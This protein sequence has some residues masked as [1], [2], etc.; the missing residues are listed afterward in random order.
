[1]KQKAFSPMTENRKQKR[2]NKK[3]DAKAKEK[4]K[5]EH[6]QQISESKKRVAE[7]Y[8]QHLEHA[9][10]KR[11]ELIK[12]VTDEQT[13]VTKKNGKT[14]Y[15]I[16]V[17]QNLQA[18]EKFKK[19]SDLTLPNGDLNKR[20]YL[21]QFY[22]GKEMIERGEIAPGIKIMTKL[23]KV[24]PDDT[25]VLQ[26][27]GSAS[28]KINNYHASLKFFEEAE[29]IDPD[30]LLVQVAIASLY[31]RIDKL[32]LAQ[33]KIQ[34]VLKNKNLDTQSESE[35]S[36][37]QAHIYSLLG[38]KDKSKEFIT[39]ACDLNPDNVEFLYTMA[40]QN[41]CIKD[42]KSPYFKK[43]KKFEKEKTFEKEHTKSALMHYALFD[44]Y[45][46][47]KDYE[48]AFDYAL[49]GAKHKEKEAPYY[50]PPLIE[51]GMQQ[52]RNFF[53]DDLLSSQ[54]I[55]GYNSELPVFVTGMPRSGTTLLEQIILSHPEMEGVGEDAL[56]GHM[57]RN[58]SY[59]KKDGEKYPLRSLHA[60]NEYLSP[61][62]IGKNY[63][64]YLSKKYPDAKRIINKSISN[65]VWV[66]Y[67]S[68]AL[69][70]ARF[71]H[72]KRNA[73]DS[74]IS[75]FS[76]NFVDNAQAY[77]Y[78]LE[79]LGCQYKCYVEMMDQWNKQI[80]D[81]I[82]NVAYEDIVEDLEGQARRIIDFLGLHW[83]DQCLKFYE[84]KNVVRTASVAQVRQPIFKSA[85]GRWKRYG[86]KV[87]PLIK[88]LGHAAPPEAIE[89]M[90]QHENSEQ[91]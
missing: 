4:A 56:I 62:L 55:Q 81:R 58:Y 61:E 23:L 87:I 14:V 71:I 16:P 42:K 26:M 2:A 36:A 30:N 44:C 28:E 37:C 73:M 67:L 47:M 90:K 72:I 9:R 11:D 59:I 85:V 52:I 39:R 25:G 63:V 13:K 8:E 91:Q 7:Q 43:L 6:K 84:T 19:E 22:M 31:S 20:A 32:D 33:E 12:S 89:Y 76:K 21:D 51:E 38:E 83:D 18:L 48:T 82:L 40:T 41:K 75:T 74:C 17:S 77:S 45:D 66:G 64:D 69:P 5:K 15:S 65:Y 53:S 34:K 78:D 70:Q 50:D 49:L 35:A 1:M 80:G 86:P 57:I 60:G 54:D 10:S 3:A 24:R 27:M 88:A 79:K 68:M 29:R 46:A